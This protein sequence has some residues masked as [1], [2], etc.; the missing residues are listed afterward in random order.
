MVNNDKKLFKY[1]FIREIKEKYIG[2]I[3]GA[4]WL[5]I[6]P[7]ML[8]FVYWFV[9]TKIFNTRIPE[10]L[11]VGFIVYLAIGLWPWLA[12]SESLIQSITSVSKNSDLI[13]KNKLDFKIPVIASITATFFINIISYVVVLFCLSIFYDYLNITSMLLLIIPIIILYILAI[14][15]G[16]IFSATQIFI[17]DTLPLI[18]TFM[19]F[20]FFA[21]PIIYSETMIPEKYLSYMKL[22]PL[23]TPISFIHKSVLSSGPL[24]WFDIITLL[25]I[26]M[27]LFYASIKYF[28]KLS[29]HFDEFK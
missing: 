25:V 18:T 12:F 24:P 14:S 8:L 13:G 17:K 27:V 21:T 16:L 2:N 29:A 9:F 28:N 23:Y 11:H 4:A 10:S 26:V 19:L 3:L 5:F 22:N 20:W 7:I 1:Y 6:Q 15:L